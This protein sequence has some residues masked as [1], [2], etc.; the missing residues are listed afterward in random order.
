MTP[1]AAIPD[2][3]WVLQF[4]QTDAA[5]NTSTKVARTVTI[6]TIALPPVIHAL[7][8]NPPEYL[9]TISGTSEPNAQVT[10]LDDLGATVGTASADAAGVWSIQL[11]DP[12]RDGAALSATQQDPAGNV[13]AASAPTLPI[14]FQR[15]TIDASTF[16]PTPTGTVVTVQVSGTPGQQV[17]IL[18]DGTWTGNTHT[19][20]TSPI[21]R[22]TPALASGPHTIAVRY[23][24]PTT[25]EIGSLASVDITVG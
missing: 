18:I 22:V 6:D 12:L 20:G 15:P 17:Q 2:G 23:Y 4:V 10:L 1:T 25:G 24:D 14:T 11:P 21:T 5:G 13:S 3:T 19:L 7:P 8:A 9:P 16:T